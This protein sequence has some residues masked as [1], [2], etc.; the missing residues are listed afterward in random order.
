MLRDFARAPIKRLTLI[1]APP[2]Y[3]KTSLAGQWF[4]SLNR[5][6]MQ[7]KWLALSSEDEDPARFFVSIADALGPTRTVQSKG[8][9]NDQGSDFGSLSIAT[10][11]GMIRTRVSSLRSPLV[12]FLDD[13]HLART[14]SAEGLLAELLSAPQYRKLRLVL[15][16]RTA[17]RLPLSELRLADNLCQIGPAELRF[18]RI[19]AIE[20]LGEVAAQLDQAQLSDLLQRAEGWPVALQMVRVLIRENPQAA[21]TLSQLGHD[22]DMGRFLSEQVVSSLPDRV[23]DFL[24]MTAALPEFSA[25]LVVAACDDPDARDL[26]F[27]LQDFALP[28]AYV[29]EARHWIRYHPVFRGF[30]LEAA[31]RHGTAPA[32]ILL[33]ASCWFEARGDIERAIRHALLA[34]HPAMAARI[35]E[36][37]GGWRIIYRS[38]RGLGSLFRAVG[39]A[40]GSI[41]LRLYP[42]TALGIAIFHVKAG[43]TKA[44]A[45]YLRMVE[46]AADPMDLR[47][48]RQLRVVRALFSLYADTTLSAADLTALEAD[49]TAD[50]DLEQVHRGLALNLLAF[51]FLA[52][53]QLERTIIYGEL[54]FRC[55][56]DSGAYFGAM[57]QHIHIGQAAYFS[58]NTQLAEETYQ[59]LIHDAQEHI[60]PGCDLDA[61]GQVLMSELLMQRGD[62]VDGTRALD[63]AMRHV[64]RHDG[65]FDIFAA[66]FLT[67]QTVSRITND[68][69]GAQDAIFDARRWAQRRGFERLS[70][71][72]ERSQARLL[73]FAGSPDEAARCA[74]RSHMGRD[75]MLNPEANDLSLRLRGSVP[76]IFWIQWFMAHGDLARAR[77]VLDSLRNMQS[78]RLHVPNR[79]ELDLVDLR[80][81][82]AEGRDEGAIAI[83]S[84]LLIAVPVRDFV[85]AFRVEVQDILP[86]VTSLACRKGVPYII[87]AQLASLHPPTAGGSPV[88]ATQPDPA[89][90]HGSLDLTLREREILHL[91]SAGRTNKEICRELDLTE[92]TVKFHLRNIFGKL[93]VKTRTAAIA[94]A[95]QLGML[96]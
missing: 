10:L 41:D 29:D 96:H 68:L 19:E 62:F 77:S 22:P 78:T 85:A 16:S 73:L 74:E 33:R 79:I 84:D 49:L 91:I 31:H 82:L 20:F 12:L 50:R 8:G 54:A 9:V 75:T 66:G 39:D 57:H 58:G 72:V 13:F 45:H 2:G 14:P 4:D 70:R 90:D 35:L 53:T 47:L 95:R 60:G 34:G 92:N 48:A 38:F 87:I 71:L 81:A 36:D 51:N 3:G 21:A 69:Q 5:E 59:R 63:W 28:F 30:L 43:Q 25:D 83:L 52:R 80:L 61:I 44:A 11:V 86:D 17:P 23:Q 56:E 18:S 46:S 40:A 89:Q 32:E 67:R 27:G 55:M 65:W 26:F 93:K 1:I 7:T 76:A 15:I 6:G 64:E 42:L 24:L 94:V 88:T 37:A